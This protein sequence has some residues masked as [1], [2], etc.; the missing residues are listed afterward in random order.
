[1]E[2]GTSS[3]SRLC[4]LELFN[5]PPLGLNK[6]QRAAFRNILSSRRDIQLSESFVTQPVRH[7]Q[8]REQNG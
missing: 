2:N 1:M 6:V 3:R 5:K 4:I 8:R 7:L